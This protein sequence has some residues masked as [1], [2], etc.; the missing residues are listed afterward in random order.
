MSWETE[1]LVSPVFTD[2]HNLLQV[3]DREG[4]L[5]RVTDDLDPYSTST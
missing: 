2:L 1:N 4:V 5:V 3:R